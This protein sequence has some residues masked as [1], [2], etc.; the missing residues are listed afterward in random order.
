MVKKNIKKYLLF[1]L[2]ILALAILIFIV[3]GKQACKLSLSDIETTM[4]TDIDRANRMLDNIRPER[5]SKKEQADYC[6]MKALCS[7]RLFMQWDNSRT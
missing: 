5:L 1:A 4:Q 7:A 3:I 6:R 2:C